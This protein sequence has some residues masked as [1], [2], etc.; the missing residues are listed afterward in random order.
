MDREEYDKWLNEF[1]GQGVSREEA[2]FLVA[3]KLDEKLN[4]QYHE[5]SGL[6]RPKKES[7]KVAFEGYAK[8]KVKIPKGATILVFYNNTDNP[9]LDAERKR[10]EYRVVWTW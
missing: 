8:E 10:P 6:W 5:V 2:H 7:S 4:T 9:E 3:K 1:V